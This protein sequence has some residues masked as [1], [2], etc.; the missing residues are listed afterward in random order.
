MLNL[1]LTFLVLAIIAGF[2]GFG[3]VAVAFAGTAKIFFYIFLILLL[4]SLV[5]HLYYP[6]RR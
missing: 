2:L 5:Q 4:L 1:V 3:G 6:K